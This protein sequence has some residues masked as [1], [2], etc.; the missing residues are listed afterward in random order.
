MKLRQLKRLELAKM[1]RGFCVAQNPLY[2]LDFYNFNSKSMKTILSK[3]LKIIFCAFLFTSFNTTSMAQGH[4]RISKKKAIDDFLFVWNQIK[5]QYAYF[6]IKQVD[7]EQVKIK[8][9]KELQKVHLKRDVLKILERLTYELYDDHI[10]LNANLPES[11]R[12]VPSGLLIWAEWI[13]DEV[14][15]S[16]IKRPFP[17]DNILL[18]EGMKI[19]AINGKDVK[20]ATDIFWGD[21]LLNHIPEARNWAIRKMI[22]GKFNEPVRL[23]LTDRGEIIDILINYDFKKHKDEQLAIKQ[24]LE[25]SIGYIRINNSLG[26]Y[27]LIGIFDSLLNSLKHTKGLIIDLRD[28]PSGGN[29]TVAKGILGRFVDNEYTYQKY[30]YPNDLSQYKIKTGSFDIVFPRGE[31]K[32]DKPL[33]IL[34]GHWTGSMGE[35]LAIGFDAIKGGVVIGTKSSGLLG[36]VDDFTIPNLKIN[37]SFPTQK[38][39]HVNGTPRE[40]FI[41]SS[42]VDLI[43]LGTTS[44]DDIILIEA[45]RIVNL[46]ISNKL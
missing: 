46:K 37:I 18:K 23:S 41:P 5:S 2:Y 10:N 32:Y 22:A 34:T 33:V 19:L 26:E 38:T 6:D 27:K 39:F 30:L 28:T 25:D 1:I 45:I 42:E 13:E 31:F 9:I 36:S 4:K 7:W 17:I 8:Y 12:I 43:K 11:Y 14:I 20:E 29:T 24:I 3:C 15:I 35:G 44:K 21:S 16:E 40:S